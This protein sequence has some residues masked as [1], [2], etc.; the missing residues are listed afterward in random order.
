MPMDETWSTPCSRCPGCQADDPGLTMSDVDVGDLVSDAVAGL[1]PV[2]SARD[3]R[4]AVRPAPGRA[5]ATVAATEIQRAVANLLVNGIRHTPSGGE[6]ET[7]VTAP[8]DDGVLVTVRD[9][10][11]GIP[12]GLAQRASSRP[13]SE[14]AT[15]D[16]G[17]GGGAGLGLAIVAGVAKAHGGT[18]SVSRPN[19]RVS[20]LAVRPRPPRFAAGT[21]GGQ[22][23]PN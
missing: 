8:G 5:G 4:L 12:E 21:G 9:Q 20:L 6:V 23:D 3:V 7:T 22:G 11:G 15:H 14:G 19:G 10:C 18:V 13:G 16:P 2:A 1:L 17:D